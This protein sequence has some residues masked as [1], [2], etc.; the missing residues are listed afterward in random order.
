MKCK[1]NYYEIK[2]AVHKV[3]NHHIFMSYFPL[4]CIPF[5]S[6]NI[7]C[8]CKNKYSSQQSAGLK[9]TSPTIKSITI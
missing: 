3:E 7:L 9:A 2:L 6:S 5:P 1:T 4:K 8:K